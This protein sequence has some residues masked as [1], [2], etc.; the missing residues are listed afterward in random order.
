MKKLGKALRLVVSILFCLYIILILLLHLPFI[1]KKI[2]EGAAHALSE[3]IGSTVHVGRINLGLLNR[4]IIDDISIDDLQGQEMLKASRV[5]TT[6][7]F[8]SLLAGKVDINTAQLF[9][10]TANL[11]RETPDQPLN[12]DFLIQAFSSDNDESTPIN[13][14][15]SSFIMRHANIH[16][17]VRSEAHTPGRFNPNHLYLQDAGLTAMIWALNDDSL[18]LDIKRCDF[19]E[20]HSGFALNK[21]KTK[22]LATQ[23]NAL[24]TDFSISTP[25]SDIHLET[26]TIDYHDWSNAQAFQVETTFNDA[27]VT[28]ADFRAF[29]PRLAHLDIPF[30]ISSFVQVSNRA[31][32]LNNLRITDSHNGLS[33]AATFHANGL[34]TTHPEADMDVQDI[35]IQPHILEKLT[36]AF[37]EDEQTKTLLQ[38]LGNVH[39]KGHLHS[40]DQQITANTELQSAIGQ[41]LFD[42]TYNTQQRSAMAHMESDHLHLGKLLGNDH[43][44]ETSFNLSVNGALTKDN[45][46]EGYIQGTIESLVYDDYTYDGITL[47]GTAKNNGYTG[48]FS[49]D[50]ENVRLTMNGTI[51]NIGNT[52]MRTQVHLAVNEFNPHALHLINNYSGESV[53]LIANADIQGNTL[54]NMVGTLQVDSLQWRTPDQKIYL[55]HLNIDAQQA[56]D[57]TKHLQVDTDFMT[58]QAQ[59]TFRYHALWPAIQSMLAKHLPSLIHAKSAHVDDTQMA[60]H[61]T[62]KDSPFLQHFVAADLS[63]LQPIDLVG[64]FSTPRQ[65]ADFTLTA[66]AFIHGETEYQDLYLKYHNNADYGTAEGAI[67]RFATET[68]LQLALQAKAQN[69]RLSTAFQWDNP[70]EKRTTGNIHTATSFTNDYTHIQ[71]LPSELSLS[72]TAWTVMPADIHIN[73]HNGKIRC[74]HIKIANGARFLSVNGVI[75]DATEDQLAIELNDM[76]IDYLQSFTDFRAVMF[77]GIAKGNARISSVTNNPRF[78]ADLNVARLCLNN[79]LIGDGLIHARWDDEHQGVGLTA[80]FTDTTTIDHFADEQQLAQPK[81]RYTDVNGYISTVNKNINLKIGAHNTSATFLNGFIGKTFK[82]IHGDVN[83][84]INVVGPLNDINLVGDVSANANMTLNA[85]N[86]TY[87]VNPADTIRLRPYAFHFDGIELTD[88]Y[89]NKG[90]VNGLLTHRNMKNFAYRFDIQMQQLLTYEEDH[91]NSDKF[92]GTVFA[93]GRLKVDGSDGHPLHI[94]ADITPTRGSFFAYDSGTPD[95]ITNQSFITF[96]DPTLAKADDNNEW[97]SY[98]TQNQNSE[99]TT[100]AYDYHG[101]IFLDANIH[102]TPECPIRLRMDNTAD[103]YINTYGNGTL[104][105]HYHNKSPFTMN[106]IYNIQGGNYRLYLQDVIHRDLA[107][108]PGSR[109]VFN[110]NPFD[111]NIHLICW[112][113]LSAVPLSDL[114]SSASFNS[115]NKVKV[116]CVLDIIGQLGN[117][118]FNFDIQLPNVSDETRQLVRSLISTDEEMNMQMIYLLGVGRFYTNEYARAT[119]ESTTNGAVNNL[120]SSTISGQINQMLSNVIGSDSKWNFGTGLSTGERGWDDLDIEGILSGRL[121]D[122]RLLINGN[123]GY[124]DN[125]L[126]QNA[127]FIGDF[128]IRW[129]IRPNGNTY[130]KA[131]NQ[132]ND[133]YFTK[134]TLNTQGIGISFQKNFDTWKRLLFR[135]RKKTENP[136]QP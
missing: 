72:D 73:R 110:G 22:L 49:I 98:P 7:N 51:E 97:S 100:T 70:T 129:R 46:P 62:M 125:A 121:L 31:I 19:V 89:Q 66:P 18:S 92:M 61:V 118:A 59:G 85:T 64:E 55:H 67:K 82:H 107:L 41:L 91:F 119:G 123:F 80:H 12:L 9:G 88:H 127:S 90:I 8:F 128:D 113:T 126:T 40:A 112:H 15:I 16:Y 69:D 39:L 99:P 115:N 109:V 54:D 104:Q 14:H 37:V 10:L 102:L 58:L 75:S 43:F 50:D 5:S 13:L 17:D 135:R 130:L 53:R 47:D 25:E 114:T 60:F 77:K 28:P 86:V 48:T 106:G 65:T 56:D 21:L 136:I 76:D 42:G 2:G 111:A 30:H 63:L 57:N 96:N 45:I 71:I 83:G 93:D 134:S 24:F 133:R 103:G 81:H 3:K 34:A 36:D 74:Q 4:I 23:Q 124:R 94:T 131:Y 44:G 78:Y 35:S 52:H 84:T 20:K 95:V 29:V 32:L 101:D 108:Q 132:N 33:V 68:P 117:M 11:Y 6:I 122:D 105:A 26:L 120:L 87:H 79:G 1:Q 116:I 38:H 27:V